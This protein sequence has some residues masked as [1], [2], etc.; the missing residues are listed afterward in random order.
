MIVNLVFD[1]SVPPSHYLAKTLENRNSTHCVFLDLAKAFDSVSYPQL[2]LKL[3][4]LGIT[5]DL[6]NCFK[7]F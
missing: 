3:E 5:G 2:L 6:L 1:T 4:V 7:A